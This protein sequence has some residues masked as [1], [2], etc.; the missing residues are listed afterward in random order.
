MR[1]LRQKIFTRQEARAMEEIY[2]A[3]RTGKIGRD[4]SARNFIRA[5]NV[6]NET[7]DAL[8]GKKNII[9][10]TKNSEAIRDIGLPETS[11][12]Y[13]RM[14]EKYTNPRLFNRFHRIQQRKQSGE[15][16]R[17]LRKEVKT[18]NPEFLDPLSYSGK[19]SNKSYNP[20]FINYLK[21]NSPIETKD[22]FRKIE[23]IKKKRTGKSYKIG[24]KNINPN[25]EEVRNIYSDYTKAT[26][27]TG[28]RTRYSNPEVAQ[29]AINDIKK[30]GIKVSVD[31]T[32]PS[33]KY[34]KE[35]SLF[36]P[37]EHSIILESKQS[38]KNPST[39]LHEYGHYLSR[40]RGQTRPLYYKTYNNL[41]KSDNALNNLKQSI[42]NRVSDLA[43]LTEEANSSY[44][45]A[46]REKGYGSTKG[47]LR[48][49]KQNLDNSFRTYE[50]GSLLG[51]LGD[52]YSRN[53]AKLRLE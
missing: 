11:K 3:L 53:L 17:E 23:E 32:I 46:A 16:L 35:I 12:A 7:I 41:P 10:Y 8:T 14:M 24:L 43:T 29:K 51:M 49:G 36:G 20:G 52:K 27:L 44:I 5:R 18:L 34:E 42:N 47:Q 13:R 6:S 40:K 48:M 19:N 39:I 30:K 31:T 33:S 26:N 4:L 25:R 22:N 15:K 2:Q 21:K 37:S 50:L 9:D 28:N 38:R 45:A 1:I